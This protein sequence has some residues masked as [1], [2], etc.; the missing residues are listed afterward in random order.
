[1]EIINHKLMMFYV[2]TFYPKKEFN[3][4]LN[5]KLNMNPNIQRFHSLLTHGLKDY[6]NLIVFGLRKGIINE[7][8]NLEVNSYTDLS[9]YKSRHI[10]N[11]TKIYKLIK[12]LKNSGKTGIMLLDIVQVKSSILV[13][14]LGKV[15][16]TKILSIVT[17]RPEDIY[18]TMP[19][20]RKISLFMLKRS[21]SLIVFSR[22]M[23]EYYK[24]AFSKTYVVVDTIVEYKIKK[25]PFEKYENNADIISYSGYISKSY[26]IHVLI[27]SMKYLGGFNLNL[28][29]PIDPTYSYEFKLALQSDSVNYGGVLDED[30]LV[31]KLQD[32]KFLINP[33]PDYHPS[34]AY[35]FPI[36]TSFYM[37]VGIS[38]ISTKLSGISS[39][40]FNFIHGI[41]YTNA[42]EL[43]IEIQSISKKPNTDLFNSA[44]KAQ[45]YIK[46]NKNYK[47]VAKL[48]FEHISA[49]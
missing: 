14:F 39:V 45:E 28:Y 34:S 11:L 38:T 47:V 12:E 36:K 37:R 27:E 23:G 31:S 15:F 4:L 1:M 42:E 35:S 22:N 48:I 10:Y 5:L 8:Y 9:L 30:L 19:L 41:E 13:F 43:A 17:D 46:K 2:A 3:N 32:S 7:Q 6:Y 16:G 24:T 20:R 40:Y 33:R 29:G 25:I 21:D 44:V 26:N 18:V 49:N